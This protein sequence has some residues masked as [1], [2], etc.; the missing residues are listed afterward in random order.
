MASL[1]SYKLGTSILHAIKYE[2]FCYKCNLIQRCTDLFFLFLSEVGKKNSDYSVVSWQISSVFAGRLFSYN[3]QARCNFD[4]AY[5]WSVHVKPILFSKGFKGLLWY[6]Y[7]LVFLCL[8]VLLF[9]TRTSA[10]YVL[11][12]NTCGIEAVE[13]YVSS[14]KNK[15]PIV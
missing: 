12:R 2:E 14:I 3:H 11:N 13:L 4:P 1:S 8:K 10:I 15:P 7:G 9:K 5:A 6:C